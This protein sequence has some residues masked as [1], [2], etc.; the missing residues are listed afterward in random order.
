MGVVREYLISVTAAALICSVAVK[1]VRNGTVG[2]VIK[3]LTGIL[4]ALVVLMPLLQI[5]LGNLELY[6]DD[7]RS[8]AGIVAGN[9]ETMAKKAMEEIIS[10]RVQTYILDKAGSL[11]AVL[12]VHVGL[13]DCVPCCVTL[14][15]SISPYSKSVLQE[16]IRTQLGIDVEDQIWIC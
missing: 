15:G 11:G 3:L 13:E 8:E 2:A 7:V 10:Q 12:S 16:Y 4:M 9:G 14:E 1:L 6:I 5:R